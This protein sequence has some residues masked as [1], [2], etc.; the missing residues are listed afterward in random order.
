ML[1]YGQHSPIAHPLHHTFDSRQPFR[2]LEHLALNRNQLPLNRRSKVRNIQVPRHT[3]VLPGVLARNDSHASRH[4]EE[5]RHRPAVDGFCG[6]VIA[7]Q[8]WDGERVRYSGVVAVGLGGHCS[9][10]CC[11]DEACVEV[12]RGHVGCISR[13]ELADCVRGGLVLF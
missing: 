11:S 13:E 10:I 2:Q 9:E 4:V 1:T 6:S 3:R 12:V 8:G 5:R 7:A